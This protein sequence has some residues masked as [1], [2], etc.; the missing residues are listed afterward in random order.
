MNSKHQEVL[1]T[2]ALAALTAAIA[3]YSKPQPYTLPDL[4][5]S[6]LQAGNYSHP[7]ELP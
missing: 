5:Q 4:K 2:L 1:K 3:A 7:N 6:E